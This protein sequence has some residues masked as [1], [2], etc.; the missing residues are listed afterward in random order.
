M[1]KHITDRK[2]VLHGILLF[3]CFYAL[4]GLISSNIAPLWAKYVPLSEYVFAGFCV[5]LYL[6]ALYVF[7]R[8]KKFYVIPLYVVL[9]AIVFYFISLQAVALKLVP[10]SQ[11]EFARSNNITMCTNIAGNLFYPVA[12]VIAYVKYRRLIRTENI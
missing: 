9:I 11:A 8:L 10:L 1:K 5:V 7:F 3:F 2:G 6:F 4:F 12:V